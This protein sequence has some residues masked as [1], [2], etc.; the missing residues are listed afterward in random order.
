M[1]SID[2]E[3][4]RESSRVMIADKIIAIP[5]RDVEGQVQQRFVGDCNSRNSTSTPITKLK[6]GAGRTPKTCSW[7]G[8][9]KRRL[10]HPGTGVDAEKNLRAAGATLL[11]VIDLRESFDTFP[12]SRRDRHYAYGQ[13]LGRLQGAWEECSIPRIGLPPASAIAVRACVRETAW[14]NL[15]RW[16]ELSGIAAACLAVPLTT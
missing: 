12:R 2:F 15:P 9:T 5:M 7:H 6:A 11:G 10:F 1:L 3:I 16:S 14:S 8:E 4:R 13:L